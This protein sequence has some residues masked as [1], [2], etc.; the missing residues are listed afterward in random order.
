[1]NDPT[2][3]NGNLSVDPDLWY[4][5]ALKPSLWDLHLAPSSPLINAGNPGITDPDGG[6]SDIGMFGGYDADQYD[7]DQDGAPSWWAP[8]PYDPTSMVDCDDLDP[9]VYPGNGC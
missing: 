4:L 1:M 6:P 2:G 9:W 8:G 5:A 7:L 3:T